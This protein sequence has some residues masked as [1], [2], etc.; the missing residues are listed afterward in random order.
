MYDHAR[1]A[2][3]YGVTAENVTFDVAKIIARKNKVVRKLVAGIRQRGLPP[4]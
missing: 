4:V 3:R 1:E 2:S